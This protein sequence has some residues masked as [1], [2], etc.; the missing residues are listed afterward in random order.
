MTG[1]I[2]Y[3]TRF[4]TFCTF[5]R[6]LTVQSKMGKCL[7]VQLPQSHPA[8]SDYLEAFEDTAAGRDNY[9]FDA[10]CRSLLTI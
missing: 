1:L 5:P 2:L 9:E 10:L 7:G 4:Y 3:E 8:Y 6:F